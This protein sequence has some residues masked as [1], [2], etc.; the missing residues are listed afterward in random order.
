MNR[1]K[2]QAQ[3]RDEL[4]EY[5]A[6]L[7]EK[8]RDLVARIRTLS[9]ENRANE[10]LLRVL[11][12]FT[13]FGIVLFD[14]KRRVIQINKAAENILQIERVNIIGK[15]CDAIFNCY[16][17]RQLCPVLDENTSL[18]RIETDCRTDMCQCNRHLLRSV[19]K[20]DNLDETV[21]VEAFV[22]ISP[23]KQAQLEIENA[24]QTK[25]NFLAKVSH[26]L[27]TPLNAII[28]F[29]ELLQDSFVGK[30]EQ[31]EPQYLK[32]IDRASKSLL[33]MVD[34]ILDITRITAK[35]L[36]LDEYPVDINALLKQLRNEFAEQC[37]EQQNSFFIECAEDTNILQADPNRLHQVLFH[38]IDNAC[39]FTQKGEVKLRVIKK[40]LN[41]ADWFAFYVKDNGIGMSTEQLARIF[42]EFEQVDVG[43]TRRH[44]GAGLGLTLCSRISALMGGEIQVTSEL[45]VGTE[46]VLLLPIKEEKDES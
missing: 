40:S 30:A 10:S 39:K 24:N 11:L 41:G 18:D 4:V 28:G 33:R 12:E 8:N 9:E 6:Q 16:A 42:N 17:D 1:T 15:S 25:D 20:I 13:P 14:D 37:E 27:R 3:S 34:E 5:S 22:D 45:G 29:T 36:T 32:N 23:I 2:K 21:L 46:A 43:N 19:V 31:A 44:S 38:L 35:R 7:E 26:E